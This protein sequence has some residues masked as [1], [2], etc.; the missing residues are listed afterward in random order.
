MCA[1]G[2]E[3]LQGGDQI[4]EGESGSAG[5]GCAFVS[6]LCE[7][8]LLAVRV[9]FQR[10]IGDKGAGALLG[11]EDAAD[12]KLAVGSHD[13]VGIDSEF[14]SYKANR[15]ELLTGAQG[16]A[17]N[18]GLDLVDELPVDGNTTVAVEAEAERFGRSI[19]R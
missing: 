7:L 5:A 2:C 11:I 3:L 10:A 18:G 6:K 1:V 4:V 9:R 12:F 19:H 8:L 15:G 13:G 17:G 14:N 16:T